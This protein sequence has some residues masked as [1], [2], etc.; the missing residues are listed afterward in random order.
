MIIGKGGAYV[1]EMKERSGAFVQLSQK[2]D[3][4]LPERVITIIGEEHA[5]RQGN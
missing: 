4:K 1:R 3:V 5:N 2:A